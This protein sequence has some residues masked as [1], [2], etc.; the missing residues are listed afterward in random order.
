MNFYINCTT[1][2]RFAPSLLP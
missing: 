1:L 2:A